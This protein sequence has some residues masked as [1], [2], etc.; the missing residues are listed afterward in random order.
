[1]YRMTTGNIYRITT[2]YGTGFIVEVDEDE[3]E[4][5]ALADCCAELQLKGYHITSVT[6]IFACSRK[7]P[8][9]SVLSSPEYER[10][11][12]EK[13]AREPLKKELQSLRSLN[14]IRSTADS[15]WLPW[16]TVSE[17]L[18][19]WGKVELGEKYSLYIHFSEEKE[20]SFV[21][22]NEGDKTELVDKLT[23]LSEKYSNYKAFA[24]TEEGFL[25]VFGAAALGVMNE[26]F[27]TI[28]NGFKAKFSI[29]GSE[30]VLFLSTSQTAEDTNIIE[31]PF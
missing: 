18:T 17:V 24:P 29:A 7:T 1:M 25:L 8:R 16:K 22:S 20:F 11:L 10:V 31:L 2:Y 5:R 6:R 9:V 28:C 14:D 26:I 30:G 15:R 21:V 12:K 27:S 3:D 13:I 4:K 19:A 23:A